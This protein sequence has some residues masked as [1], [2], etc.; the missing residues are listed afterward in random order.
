MPLFVV[1]VHV[2]SEGC[3]LGLADEKDII[4]S[5]RNPRWQSSVLCKD[6]YT[7][8]LQNKITKLLQYSSVLA[9]F[10]NLLLLLLLMV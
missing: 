3:T 7:E 5:F 10:K 2:V 9:S 4:D 6:F 8:C 1:L